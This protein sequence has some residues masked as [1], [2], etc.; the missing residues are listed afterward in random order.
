M[1]LLFVH[2]HPFYKDGN[3]VYSGGGLPSEIWNNYLLNFN[4]VLVYGRNSRKL[5]DKK[6]LSSIS[7][8]E[9]HLTDSYNSVFDIFKNIHKIYIE[10][11][12]LIAQADVV[13]VRL[14]SVLGI[15]AGMRTKRQNKLLWVEQ[16]GN[17]YEALSSEGSFIG[18]VSAP[19]INYL[20]K[21]TVI[22]A[23]FISYVTNNKLQRDY[24]SNLKSKN[25]VL[26]D[27]IINSLLSEKE[28]N[29]ER[30][31][32]S[33]FRIGLIGG[34]DAKYKG[35]DVLLYAISLLTE[36][37]RRNIKVSF[38]GKGEYSWVLSLAES[39]NLKDN[40]ECVGSLE[41]GQ[42]INE[43]LK[44]LTLYVQ[45]SLTEGMPRATIEAMAMGCPVIGS[46]VGGIPDIVTERFVHK[47]KN[48]KELAKHIEFLYYNRDVL[49]LES[50][51]SLEKAGPYLKMNLDK[52]R[53]DFYTK[54]NEVIK[55]R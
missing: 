28:C 12:C 33:L 37:V 2:D 54:M 46:N 10:L 15:V 25:V 24:P 29:S 38:I 55:H 20:N 3:F 53:V 50:I 36:N 14:P 34:F 31:S 23:D 52:K 16:V 26:S 44:K 41:S 6:V 8:V 1:I 22:K 7:K 32:G 27:V 42:E 30:F 4:N 51:L 9:F 11:D 39:L 43:F 13:L 40:I 48:F 21:K 5:K 47:R 45:P 49:E 18:K 17:A 35:Q 19:F